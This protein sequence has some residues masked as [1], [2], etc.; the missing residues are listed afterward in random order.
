MGRAANEDRSTEG[1]KR[2]AGWKKLLKPVRRRLL[3]LRTVRRIAC[4][5]S[6]G[7]GAA[8]LL[9]TAARLWPIANV[10]WYAAGLIGT[11]LLAGAWAGVRRGVTAR[12]A[13][14][15]MDRDGTE[16]AVGTALGLLHDNSAVARLQRQDAAALAERYVARLSEHLPWPG[17]RNVRSFG[18][19]TALLGAALAVLLL[20][21]N[22]LD[23]MLAD[24]AAAKR[25]TAKLDEAAREAEAKLKENGLDN[26]QAEA[27]SESLDRLRDRL[28]K[29]DGPAGT[30]DR[31]EEAMREMDRLAAEL[32]KLARRMAG[33]LGQSGDALAARLGAEAG[34][35]GAAAAWNGSANGASGEGGAAGASEGGAGAEGSSGSGQGSGA[36]SGSGQ[37]AGSGPGSG[38]D[39][40]SDQGAGSGS[41][42]GGEGSG[43]NSV[44][45][46]S[47]TGGGG[48]GF[49]QGGRTLVTTPRSLAGSGNIQKDGGPASGGEI[50]NDGTAPAVDGGAQSYEAVFSE[51]EAQARQSLNR[52][53]LPQSMQE[54]V[55]N[56]FEEIQPNR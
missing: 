2:I 36:G 7:V 32:K 43:G 38:S 27:L 12:E 30:L 25:E 28:G 41:G 26:E 55:R 8:V 45:S 39:S 1:A 10:R 22:P 37:G 51:Y 23:D 14:M 5:L 3:V 19:G 16:D 46:G 48:A 11:A 49:G 56:Y 4:G 47:G 42:G 29:L 40:G 53:L 24:R 35:G 34:A 52:S 15:A 54:R 31:I 50:S 33:Q 20:L 17:W 13:A 9:L 21:P 6:A 18:G 44:G